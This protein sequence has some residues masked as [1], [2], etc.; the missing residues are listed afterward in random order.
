MALSVIWTNRWSVV[1]ASLSGRQWLAVNR[2]YPMIDEEYPSGE[3]SL[4][5][6]LWRVHGSIRNLT[7]MSLT[8]TLSAVRKSSRRG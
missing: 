2:Q 7:G 5:G 6:P 1:I 8:I 4:A 3:C